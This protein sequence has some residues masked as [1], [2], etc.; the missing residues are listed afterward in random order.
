MAVDAQ[1]DEPRR[2]FSDILL[3][4]RFKAIERQDDVAA[5]INKNRRKELDW[6]L[7]LYYFIDHSPTTVR[8]NYTMSFLNN[9]KHTAHLDDHDRGPMRT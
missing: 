2:T 3:Q 8:F 6:V 7:L 4:M 9:L 1:R 5:T